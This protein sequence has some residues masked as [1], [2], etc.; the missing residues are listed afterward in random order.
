MTMTKKKNIELTDLD[1]LP[2][3]L[4]GK[5]HVVPIITGGDDVVEEVAI[6]EALPILSLRSSVL[7]PGA[8]T[9]ITV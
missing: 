6:P 7:F 3:I 8:I 1:A 9:P 4:D 5:H 2:D